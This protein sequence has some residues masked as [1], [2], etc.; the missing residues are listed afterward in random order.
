MSETTLVEPIR[1]ER[2]SGDRWEDLCGL[3]GRA[4]ASNGCWCQYWL[5]GPAYHRRDRAM[6][7]DSLRSECAHGRPPG[8]GL[9]AYRDAHA[10]GWARLSPR[11]E[12]GWLNR[13]FAGRIPG[14]DDPWS[15]SCFFVPNRYRRTGVMTALISGAVTAAGEARVTLEAYPVDPAVEK[16]TRNRFTGVLEPFLRAGFSELMRLAPDR[17]LVRRTT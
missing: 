10:V 13:R 3:F 11:S 2:V 1:V 9:I 16:A 12:L 7:R 5:L 15:L 14:G 17:A 4:G 6:N 8:P